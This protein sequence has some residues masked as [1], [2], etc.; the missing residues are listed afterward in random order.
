MLPINNKDDFFSGHIIHATG[1]FS[2]LAK[3]RSL[4]GQNV[5]L[6]ICLLS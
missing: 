3:K 2:S 4:I 5:S 6:V 1:G